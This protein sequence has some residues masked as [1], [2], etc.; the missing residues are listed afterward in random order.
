MQSFLYQLLRGVAFCH[1]KRVLHRDLK[2]QNLLI[3][4]VDRTH[5]PFVSFGLV[6]THGPM[7]TKT[8]R[9]TEAG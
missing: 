9:R 8:E 5:L 3:N 2:P 1:E 4:K 6:V 7:R